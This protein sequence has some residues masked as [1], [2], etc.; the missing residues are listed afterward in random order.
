MPSNS[1]DHDP[2]N[3]TVRDAS[4]HLF[5]NLGFDRIFGNPGSTELPMFRDFPS[6]FQYVLGL[7]ECSVVA[8]ADGYAQ[9]S[10]RAALVNL[11]S[12]AGVGHAMGSIFTAYR[13]ATPLVI[14]A[15][16]Q[17]RS[18][19]PFEP[20]LYSVQAT[21]LPKPYVK[22]SCEPARAQDVPLA[23]ARAYCTAMQYPR[24]P[25]LVSVPADDWDARTSLVQA[26]E[27][28]FTIRPS[29]ASVASIADALRK[30][31]RPAF[32]VGSEVDRNGAWHQ[33]VRLAEQQ[34]A[35]VWV[36]PASSRCC[37]PEN[38]PLFAGFLPRSREGI[39]S[40][41]QGSDL[42][43]VIG[44]PLFTYHVEGSGP[45]ASDS[46][47]I[48]HVTDDPNSAA[49]CPI[50]TSVVASIRAAVEDILAKGEPTKRAMPTG[51]PAP[52]PVSTGG[53]AID[54][55]AMLQVIA[56]NRPANSIIVEEAPSIRGDIQNHLPCVRPGSFFTASSGGLGYSLPASIGIA[57]ARTDASVIA[58]I[59]DGSSMYSIQAIWTAVEH[60]LPITFVIAN[61][62]GYAALKK[63]ARVFGMDGALGSDLK[64]IDF[65]AL[66]QGQG[67]GG[68]RVFTSDALKQALATASKRNAP[69]L[70]EVVLT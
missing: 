56:D 8:M 66:A 54:V 53:S 30:S 38:H 36:A 39:V 7:S 34:N 28:D 61:N 40:A 27:I 22:W 51:R 65:V 31:S 46:A 68:E 2:E 29:A 6:D 70:I 1:R 3:V 43:V 47:A 12:A 21:E 50:G 41:L 67:C 9:A 11:H 4:F 23:L 25:V 20:Y 26:R 59:G 45:H 69:Y 62:H 32:V 18:M 14:T 55:A 49:W 24:G 44:A 17:A 10:G 37:F 16:Q 57:M 48:F 58:L 19:L 42:V 52:Q 63:F 33:M 60:G 13:N 15:G 5:R 35:L 64:G